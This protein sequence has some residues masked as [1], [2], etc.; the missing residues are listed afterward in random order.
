MGNC[1][2]CFRESKQQKQRQNIQKIDEF[3]REL[4][5]FVEKSS[6]RVFEDSPP[7]LEAFKTECLDKIIKLR[8]AGEDINTT[9][10]YGNNGL[11]RAIKYDN[12]DRKNIIKHLFSLDKS[13]VHHKNIFGDTAITLACEFADV[14]TIKL[15]EDFGADLS[16]TDSNGRNA[17]LCAAVGGKKDVINYLHTQNNRLIDGKDG[18][19]D[20][21]ITLACKNA[22]FETVKLLD[23]LGANSNQ[24]GMDGRNALLCAASSGEKDIIKYYHSKNDQL[25]HFTDRNGDNAFLLACKNHR[26]D[27]ETVQLLVELGVDINQTDKWGRNGLFCAAIGNKVDHIKFLHSKNDQ[28]IHAKDVYG[29]TAFTFACTSDLETV[30]LLVKLGIDITHS[31][32]MPKNRPKTHNIRMFIKMD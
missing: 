19:D 16:Q 24:T 15:L 13:I 1:C 23:N 10:E 26:N 25:I 30:E 9:D 28:L 20:T 3:K 11:M 27:I 7:I 8:N 5:N 22:D 32:K 4:N 17:L 18:N 2:T 12:P 29:D 31:G 14:E 21:A 6:S